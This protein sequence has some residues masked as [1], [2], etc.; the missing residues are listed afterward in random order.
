MPR[1]TERP[2][3]RRRAFLGAVGTGITGLTG[4]LG[5]GNG[6]GGGQSD[7]PAARNL[8]AQPALGDPDAAEGLLVAFEDPSCPT[9]RRF[10]TE[11]FPRIRD[12]LVDSGD[13]AFV[14]RV[15]PIVFEW[16]KPAVQAM[17]ATYD[18]DEAA[19]WALKA[20]YYAEQ[21]A[22][23]TDNVLDRTETFLADETAVDAA[24]VV[25]D[26]RAEAHDDAVQQDLTDGEDA[27]VSATPTV[28]LFSGGEFRT[29]VTGAQSYDVYANALV[30]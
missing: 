5:G 12:E 16:G 24:A 14:Y 1:A 25:E 11:T 4:C 19:F 22:F 17:E 8:A 13:A 20:H 3:M 29:L 26:A 28:A 2:A 21:S 10:E 9:C 30:A 7:H 27:D 23:G 18:R 15:F 6:G